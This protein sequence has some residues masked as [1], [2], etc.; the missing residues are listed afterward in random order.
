[1]VFHGKENK[2]EFLKTAPCKW[3]NLWVFSRTSPVSLN[4]FH[5]IHIRCLRCVDF[6]NT[7]TMTSHERHVVLN[8][9]SFDCLF[10]SLCRPT[11]KKH[12]W[13]FMKGIDQWPVNS[14]NKHPA[15]LKMLPFDGVSNHQPYS[16]VYSGADQR[17]QQSSASLA[18]VR[19][20]HR[21]SNAENVS[22]WW[23]HHDILQ[24]GI[25]Y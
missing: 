5:C 20:N 25:P 9:R 22:I 13:P 4:R 11:S 3:R 2:H 17:K 12:Y 8:H 6:P 24:K 23:R 19:G 14:P 21:A 16:T 7:I 1:M 10:N 18:F 15:T